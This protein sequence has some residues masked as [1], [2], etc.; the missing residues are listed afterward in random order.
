MTGINNTHDIVANFSFKKGDYFGAEE[1]LSKFADSYARLTAEESEILRSKFPAKDRLGW[2][3]V[4][5]TLFCKFFSDAD[6][7]HKD[8]LCKIFFAL[9]SFENLDFGF[10]GLMDVISISEQVKNHADIARKNW[11]SFSDLTSNEMAKKN[12]ENKV[13]FST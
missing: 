4:A 3:R 6:A 9:Y 7:S 12:L 2:L 13:F 5:S 11:N 10:D 1:Q 8:R